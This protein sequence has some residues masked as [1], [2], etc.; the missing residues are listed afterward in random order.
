MLLKRDCISAYHGKLWVFSRLHLRG[1]D[2][3][4]IGKISGKIRMLNHCYSIYYIYIYYATG[5]D[6][7]AISKWHWWTLVITEFDMSRSHCLLLRGKGGESGTCVTSN[8][9]CGSFNLLGMLG[10]EPV[11][12][13]E[14]KEILGNV[15]AQGRLDWVQHFLQ[16]SPIV[17]AMFI[18]WLSHCTA[19][20][21]NL[22]RHSR[23]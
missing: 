10:T 12:S 17:F 8:S 3:K 16:N 2:V 23:V 9:A 1:G 5:D 19:D 21:T 14:L 6:G 7:M 4:V 20:M 15:P 13:P 11:M 22:K 18:F